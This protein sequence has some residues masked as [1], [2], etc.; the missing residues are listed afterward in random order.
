[1]TK[2][3]LL[4]DRY[5]R[6][7]N[8]LRLSI[9]DR[10]NLRCVY[11]MTE[12]M[13]FTPHAQ[14]LNF[15][16]I[17][18]IVSAFVSLGVNKV[19]VTGGE[20]LVRHKLTSLIRRLAA[21]PGLDHIA[22]STN[23]VMLEQHALTLRRAGLHSVNI[24]LDT[25]DSDKFRQ[26]TRVG[27]VHQVVQ[28]IDAAVGA[29]FQRVKINCVMLNGY[30]IQDILE[31]VSFARRKQIDISFIEEMPLGTITEHHRDKTYY[32]AQQAYEMI[33]NHYP[34]KPSSLDTGGPSRY[35]TMEDSGTHVGFI[36]PHSNNF[37]A[38]C[39]RVR[40]TAT[41]RLLLCLG[42]EQSVDLRAIVRAPNF[43]PMCNQA[44][45]DTISAAMHIKP[46]RHEFDHRERKAQVLRLMNT[47]GG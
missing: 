42:N 34:L 33:A 17:I 45:L 19:R 43:D 8:Y 28:G 21:I 27:S 1:M 40:L 12:R 30:N 5:G 3:T 6:R 7:I 38:S 18:A 44:L 9:T 13:R 46:L 14:V 16:E 47:T 11:C 32:S 24:S 15:D 2:N 26:M 36:S 25:L 10:C 41:G 22:L 31:L 29:G 39:N 4:S 20:P 37:C 23:G 35:Y